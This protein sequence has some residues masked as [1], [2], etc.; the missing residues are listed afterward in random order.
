VLESYVLREILGPAKEE[1]KGDWR[2]L[3]NEKHHD[4]YS[5]PISIVVIIKKRLLV[6]RT[7]ERCATRGTKAFGSPGLDGRIY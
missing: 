4:L 7:W 1:L 6:T 3:H 2:R 5:S